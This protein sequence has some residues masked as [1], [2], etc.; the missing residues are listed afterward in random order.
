MGSWLQEA[1]EEYS[2]GYRIEAKSFDV[3][4]WRMLVNAFIDYVENLDLTQKDG[5]LSRGKDDSQLLSLYRIESL[6]TDMINVSRFLRKIR[7]PDDYIFVSS[8]TKEDIGEEFCKE[9]FEV[10]R[11]DIAYTYE[12]FWEHQTGVKDDNSENPEK[13]E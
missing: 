5:F 4:G 9:F 8:L 2:R 3:N 10:I 7:P 11:D 6:S 1:I 12:Y 13:G